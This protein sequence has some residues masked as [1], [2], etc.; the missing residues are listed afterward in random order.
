MFSGILNNTLCYWRR[1]YT[2]CMVRLYHTQASEDQHGMEMSEKQ[3]RG[4][5]I[6]PI[7]GRSNEKLKIITH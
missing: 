4:Q 5:N 6:W 2:D 7:E 3:S 1:V